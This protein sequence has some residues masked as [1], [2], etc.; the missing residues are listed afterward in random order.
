MFLQENEIHL[1]GVNWLLLQLK[2]KQ[3]LINFWFILFFKIFFNFRKISKF[4]K[5]IDNVCPICDNEVKTI[6]KMK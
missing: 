5:T 2:Q 1:C 4:E 3:N 6:R